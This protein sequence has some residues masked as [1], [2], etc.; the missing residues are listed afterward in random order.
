MV[1]GSSCRNMSCCKIVVSLLNA[2]LH[3][4]LKDTLYSSMIPV[5]QSY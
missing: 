3:S 1:E 5:S 2:I 4:Y